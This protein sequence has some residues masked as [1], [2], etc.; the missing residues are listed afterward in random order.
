MK[1]LF[2]QRLKSTNLLSLSLVFLACPLFVYGSSNL[3]SNQQSLKFLIFASFLLAVVTFFYPK[4]GLAIML[5]SMLFATDVPVGEGGETTRN[6]SVS[7]RAEDLLLIII[8]GGW[9]IRQAVTRSLSNLKNVPANKPIFCMV[10]IMLLASSFGYI[11][12]TTPLYRGFFFTMK[13]IE[14]F[15]IFFMTINILD[16]QEE[17]K[18]CVKLLL[19][20]A[21]IIALL[22]IIQQILFPVA[23]GITTTAG[24]G[25]A[26]TLGSFL[27]IVIGIS[28]GVYLY[29]QSKKSILLFLLFLVLFATLIFTKSR[30][31]YVSVIPVIFVLGYI[32]KSRRF[33]NIIVLA[34]ITITG[35]ATMDIFFSGKLKILS[36]IHSD[37]F[38]QQFQSISDVATKG[39]KA[40]S[41][42]DARVSFWKGSIPEMIKYPLLGKGVGSI[43]LGTADNQYIREILETGFIG[44]ICFLYM[45]YIIAKTTLDLFRIANDSVIKGFAVGFFSG[46]VGMLIHAMTISNFYTILTMEVFWFVT[47]LIM[48]FH[49]NYQDYTTS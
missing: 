48:L 14:Y 2:D 15:W 37:D 4:V 33:I 12:G 1:S 29:E 28:L 32:T 44:L 19:G 5:I 31:A 38:G 45:N 18:T 16:T 6:R 42:L 25:R 27:L 35:L 3:I 36:Q 20:S 34:L 17:G 11:Q 26:N 10:L 8:S 30:G 39:V 47:A 49:Y 21:I 22:G 41:S 43:G 23:G 7:I 24:Y 13:R 9:L 46:H 40:D